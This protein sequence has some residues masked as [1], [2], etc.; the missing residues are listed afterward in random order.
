MVS[1]KVSWHFWKQDFTVLSPTSFCGSCCDISDKR[2]V[3]LRDTHSPCELMA[4]GAT[5]MEDLLSPHMVLTGMVWDR[6]CA[7][8]SAP[9]YWGQTQ[10]SPGDL[11]VIDAAKGMEWKPVGGHQND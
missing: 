5:L 6:G 1:A 8:T 3:I 2:A 11:G 9:E 7:V 4:G 10:L